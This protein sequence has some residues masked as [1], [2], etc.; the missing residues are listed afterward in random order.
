MDN[1]N[2]ISSEMIV[3]DKEYVVIQALQDGAKTVKGVTTKSGVS[4]QKAISLLQDLADLDIVTITQV[5]KNYHYHL[6]PAYTFKVF[7]YRANAAQDDT[8]LIHR[9]PKVL[10]ATHERKVFGKIVNNEV[11]TKH[12]TPEQLA[13]NEA[14]LHAG[15]PIFHE[16]KGV[17]VFESRHT[18]LRSR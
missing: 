16:K 15:K 11:I 6:N 17:Y 8:P 9:K 7:K 12:W 1:A 14:K 5:S 18:F 4:Y 10:K 3:T 2:E 13:E